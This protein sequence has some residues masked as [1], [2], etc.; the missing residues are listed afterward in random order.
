LSKP[1]EIPLKLKTGEQGIKP[2]NYKA[3]A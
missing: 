1:L 3:L 2:P